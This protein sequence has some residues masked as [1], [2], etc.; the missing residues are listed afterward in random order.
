MVYNSFPLMPFLVFL[1]IYSGIVNNQ[2]NSRFVRYN[3]AQAVLLDILLIVPQILLNVFRPG[4]DELG[5]QLY[6][7]AENTIFLFVCISVAYG[8]GSSLVGMTARLPL[9]AEAADRQT[10]GPGGW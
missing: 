4:S 5:Q 2:N 7:S 9:V 1:G 3:A 6:I 10:S 8:M